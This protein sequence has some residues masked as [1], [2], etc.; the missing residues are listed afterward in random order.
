MQSKTARITGGDFYISVGFE[1]QFHHGPAEGIEFFA[2]IHRRFQLAEA[3]VSRC[4]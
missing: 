1:N 3:C 2:S 4:F